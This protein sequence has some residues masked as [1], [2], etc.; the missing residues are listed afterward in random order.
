MRFS[1]M[2]GLMVGVIV[3]WDGEPPV[4]PDAVKAAAWSAIDINRAGIKLVVVD[5]VD[6]VDSGYCISAHEITVAQ[7]RRFVE[8]TGYTTVAELADGGYGLDPA[9]GVIRR[10]RR[11]FWDNIGALQREDF[12]VLNMSWADAQAFCR[13]LTKLEGVAYR[14]ATEEDLRRAVPPEFR[15]LPLGRHWPLIDRRAFD[16]YQ[17]VGKNHPLIGS[18]KRLSWESFAD[19]LATSDNGLV[20]PAAVRSALH[21]WNLTDHPADSY[22][23][24]VVRTGDPTVNLLGVEKAIDRD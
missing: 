13:W 24:R 15:H 4:D 23:F 20:W 22:G 18:R 12:P 11:F 9:S 21:G 6:G 19:D 17:L 14:L 2:V 1:F 16:W 3:L 7:F 5:S 10:E 8:D